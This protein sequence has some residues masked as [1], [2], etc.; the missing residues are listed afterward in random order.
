L[1]RVEETNLPTGGQ[2]KTPRQTR[3]SRL[4]VTQKFYQIEAKNS[5]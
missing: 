2:G 3:H 5:S 1:S 4:S